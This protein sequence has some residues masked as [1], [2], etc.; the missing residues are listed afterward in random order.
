MKKQLVK[1]LPFPRCLHFSLSSTCGLLR[2]AVTACPPVPSPTSLRFL[3]LRSLRGRQGVAG[4]EGEASKGVSEEEEGSRGDREEEEEARKL[5]A[6]G[7]DGGRGR[8]E[9]M[10]LALTSPY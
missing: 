1:L 7:S 4:G 5:L 2:K 9:D 8:R 3:G 10:L 6:G